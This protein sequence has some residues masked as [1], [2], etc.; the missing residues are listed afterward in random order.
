MNASV[1]VLPIS[2]FNCISFFS[3]PDFSDLT[4]GFRVTGEQLAKVVARD[5]GFPQFNKKLIKKA[6]VAYLLR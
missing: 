1:I 2:I 3:G 6:L 4:D 5:F